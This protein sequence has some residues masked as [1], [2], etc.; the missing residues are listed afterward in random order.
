VL[1]YG[2]EGTSRTDVAAIEQLLLGMHL[3]YASVSAA[4][5]QRLSSAQLRQS[6]LL[7]VPGGNFLTMGASLPSSTRTSVHDAVQDGLNYL[8]ICAGAFL[9]GQAAYPNFNLTSGVRFEFYAAA[10]EGIRKTVVPIATPVGPPLDQYW[11]D[12]PQLRGWGAVVAQYPDGTPAVVE[13][14]S[15]L[16]WVILTGIHAEAP[17]SWRSNLRFNTP[18]SVDNAY[19]RALIDAA[20]HGKTLPQF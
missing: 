6:R 5:L 10:R 8:G 1:L 16:G 7:I 19:A 14:R 20:V 13:G 12:G 4:D 15:G 3:A 9:A 17:E 11:E 2:G 18:A